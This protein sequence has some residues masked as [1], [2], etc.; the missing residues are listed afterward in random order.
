MAK[1]FKKKC[2]CH[3]K[4]FLADKVTWKA[5]RRHGGNPYCQDEVLKAGYFYMPYI[6]LL[7]VE[8][9]KPRSR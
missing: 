3:G 8:T 7:E 1:R 5:M 2:V 9:I 4:T 6:P